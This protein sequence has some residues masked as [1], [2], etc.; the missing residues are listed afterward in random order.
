MGD[1]AA[2]CA[3]CTGT[4]KAALREV[5]GDDHLHGLAEDL[6]IAIAK[7]HVF[8]QGGGGR[9]RPSEAPLLIDMHASEAATVLRNT[10]VTWVRVLLEDHP[11]T[12]PADTL[13]AMATWLEGHAE[14]IRHAPYGAEC[15]DEIL[16]AVHQARRATDRPPERVY[17]GPCPSCGQQIYAPDGHATARCRRDGCDGEIDDPEGRRMTMARQAVEQAPDREVTATEGA[18]AARAL[19][20]SITDRWIRK[21]D[22]MGRLEPVREKRPRKYRLGDILD[23]A[24]KGEKKAS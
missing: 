19:G 13:P 4:L 21:L 5:V 6:D 3:P 1:Q 12:A 15:V 11:T 8:P 7:Q 9:V 24:A 10:L 2:V 22:E 16:A 17:A 18:L 23:T 20:H 14:T